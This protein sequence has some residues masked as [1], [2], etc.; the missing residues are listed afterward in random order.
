M[1]E[2]G[3]NLNATLR[4]SLLSIHNYALSGEV[5]SDEPHMDKARY[6]HVSDDT[7]LTAYDR[8]RYVNVKP[9][10]AEIEGEAMIPASFAHQLRM[11]TDRDHPFIKV[12]SGKGRV[13]AITSGGKYTEET[14]SDPFS[15]KATKPVE[16]PPYDTY[17]INGRYLY[18]VA[19]LF[20]ESKRDDERAWEDWD[21]MPD[22]RYIEV[23]SHG[24][25][26]VIEFRWETQ[27]GDQYRVGVMPMLPWIMRDSPESKWVFDP[28]KGKDPFDYRYVDRMAGRWPLGMFAQWLASGERGVASDAIL[29]RLTHMP[30]GRRN[31]KQNWPVDS[32]DFRRCELLIREHPAIRDDVMDMMP[33]RSYQW[34]AIVDRWDDIVASM[35]RESPGA[36]EGPLGRCPETQLMISEILRTAEARYGDSDDVE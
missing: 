14:I 34:E 16:E 26:G 2:S 4:R 12:A 5:G 25:N 10:D 29:N 23:R 36:F 27:M 18:E 17:L 1:G 28:I 19:A 3:K 22:E 11:L 6:I 20:R 9:G 7:G 8:H 35:E 33:D 13:T 31:Y 21:A 32:E 24:V 30:V 15:L